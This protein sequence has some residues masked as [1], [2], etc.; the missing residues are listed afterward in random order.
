MRKAFT[1]IELLVVI[2]I[3]AILAAILFPVFARA[4]A[5]AKQTVCISNLNQ[6]GKAII[7][8]MADNDDVFPCALDASDKFAPEIWAAYPEFQSRIPSM[9]LLVDVLQPYVKNREV[10][11]CP[12]DTGTAILD[13]H[14]P[15][16]FKSA[17]SM[18]ATFGSSFFF[19]TEIAFKFFTQTSFQ[20]PSNVNVLFDGAGHWHVP[21]RRIE[22]TDDPA[23]AY[24]LLGQYRY[25]CLYGDMHVKSLHYAQL[26]Q[27]WDTAL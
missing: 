7:L 12:A 10:F 24:D 23:T 17:P 2:A 20:L 22:A 4:K 21:V 14:Y 6:A 19:R 16:A 9:P 13:N 5:A 11:H 26:Q 15:Q 1:L 25:D 3:I 8:Y 18:Y 27:A